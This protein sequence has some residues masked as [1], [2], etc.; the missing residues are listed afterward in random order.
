MKLMRKSNKKPFIRKSKSTG[1]MVAGF[2]NTVTGNFEID[3]VIEDG[4]TKAIDEFLEDNN[5][6]VV[7]MSF[8][9]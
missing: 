6:M 1:K 2:L 9:D 3:R 8:V 4:D 7:Q 5:I